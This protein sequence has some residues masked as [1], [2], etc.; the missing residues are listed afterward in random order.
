MQNELGTFV[1]GLL[2]KVVGVTVTFVVVLCSVKYCG[3]SNIVLLVGIVKPAGPSVL[4]VIE[5]AV[6]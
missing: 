3:C 2:V 5:V 6:S 1:E 4:T